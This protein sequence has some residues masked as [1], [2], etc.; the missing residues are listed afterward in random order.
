MIAGALASRTDGFATAT[1]AC[2]KMSDGLG[3]AMN[4]EWQVRVLPQREWYALIVL[5]L[6]PLPGR[7]TD[8]PQYRGPNHDGVSTER[9]NKNWTGS[10]TNPVWV[11]YLTN[12]LTSLT[13]SGG[14]VFTQ[15]ARSTNG[16]NREFCVALSVTSGAE[17]WATKVDDS[18]SYSGGVGF[19]DDGPRSTP[20]VEGG[21]VYV[22]TSY[23]NLCRLNATNGAVIWMTNLLAGFGGSV[24]QWQSAASPLLE[25]GMVF[26][27]ANCGTST[28]MAFNSTDGTLAWRSQD[29]AMTHSTPVLATINGM[30]QLIFATQ[31]GLVSLN[32]Q[33][34]ELLWKFPYPFSYSTSIGASPAAYQNLVFLSAI[35]G[36]GAF[37]VQIVKS[38]ATQVPVQLWADSALQDHWA[39]PACYQGA[40]F[41]QFTPDYDAAELR[42][43]DL[44][45][46]EQRWAVPDFGRGS[47]MLIGTN[48][49][50]L[51]ERGELVL[52]EA[53]TNA[54]VELAR[55]TAI[56]GYDQLRNKCWNALALS[57]GQLYVRSTAYAARF[58][59]SVP[60][61]ILD[62][63]QFAS[64]TMASLVIRTETG[65]PITSNRLSGMEVR[66]STDA[67]LPLD[68]WPKQTSAF[69]LSNGV[70][71][72]GR[73]D[74]SP[75]RRFFIVS[76]FA[77]D[78]TWPRLA[79]DSP[80]LASQRTVSFT[81]RTAAGTPISSNRLTNME[82]C[83]STNAALSP[84]LWPKLTD[85]LV[86]S[87]GVVR[88]TGADASGPQQF[89]LVREPQ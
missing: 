23:H 51:T 66:A 31:S 75:P 49:L 69:L 34:G 8:W 83:A 13:V 22:L 70:A 5:L 42:C 73:L 33:T 55:F 20:S 40:V 27:N 54:Y 86:F 7:A 15:V 38:N 25:S 82:V 1:C 77:P 76:E 56:P 62:P 50:V 53:N 58:D 44:L 35:Y 52:A 2:G 46:G 84:A 37:A 57:D 4:L 14:R 16:G 61:L 59:L 65:A 64:Q 78:P 63:P 89:F 43:I 88:L 36:M 87:N 85:V 74:A 9:I 28:L 11:V 48:L 10:V 21:S 6:L 80:Q 12:G 19:T 17:L 81:I 24:I 39:T 67:A 60:D 41:G 30:R 47:T 18:A 3:Q 71:R 32:P 29:E 26:V 79:L 45:S 68:L 72:V